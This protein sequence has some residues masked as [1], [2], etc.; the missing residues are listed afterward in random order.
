MLTLPCFLW[1]LCAANSNIFQSV[2]HSICYSILG[3]NSCHFVLQTLT[4]LSFCP[5]SKLSLWRMLVSRQNPLDGFGLGDKCFQT[6]EWEWVWNASDLV[7]CKT[8][9][10]PTQSPPINR[11]K[12]TGLTIYFNLKYLFTAIALLKF[13]FKIRLIFLSKH[14]RDLAY[15]LFFIIQT[16]KFSTLYFFGAISKKGVKPT[17]LAEALKSYNVG[18]LFFRRQCF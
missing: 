6:R 11:F 9:S 2:H 4:N 14:S 13:F 16:F 15:F 1:N 7:L 10:L 8:P 17:V 3:K 5:Y 18:H 12:E